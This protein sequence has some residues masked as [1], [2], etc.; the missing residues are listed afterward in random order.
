MKSFDLSSFNFQFTR[1]VI[2]EDHNMVAD[3]FERIVND[4][5]N[6]RVIGKAYTA[7]GCMEL[8]EA[9]P[10]DVV[11]LD[12]GLPDVQ[13][14][15]LCPQIKEKYPHI[16]VLILTSYGEMF[17]IKRALDAGAD[18]YLMKS[19]THEELHEGI[20]TVASGERYLCER[21]NLTIKK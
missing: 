13:G 4:S 17:T 6:F 19:C 2:V 12:V 21:V 16:K 8:L 20:R 5:E 14:I 10:C 1:V 11:L 9:A 18:G 15:D 3:G 7:A